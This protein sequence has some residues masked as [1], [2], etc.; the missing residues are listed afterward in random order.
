[1]NVVGIDELAPRRRS[2]RELLLVTV[3]APPEARARVVESVGMFEGRILGVGSTEVTVSLDG[4]PGKVDDFDDSSGSW[5]RRLAAHRPGGVAQLDEPNDSIQDNSVANVFYEKMLIVPHRRSRRRHHR[6]RLAGSRPRAEPEG[7]GIDVRIGVGGIGLK[8]KAEAAG[9]KVLSIATRWRSRRHHGPAPDT[10]QKAIYEA[11]I[12]ADLVDA[13]ALFFGHGF[14][15]RFGRMVPPPLWTSSWSPQ[16]PGH[17]VRRPMRRVGRALPRRVE[18]DASGHALGLGLAYADAIGG[19]RAGVIE[20]T[21]TEE[22]ETDLFG[23]QVVLCGGT[24]ALVQAGFET[25]I[26][27]GYQPEIAYF[28]CLHELKLIVDLMYEEG[29][30]GM[31]DPS[32]TPPVRGPTLGPRS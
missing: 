27:A 4:P 30:A 32:P 11:S 25:L 31:R 1:M 21:F 13:D 7:P 14:N 17:L 28:E 19:A 26:N 23:E 6:L 12:E 20:T 18:Q 16:G 2:T 15:I 10:E 5:D 29:I 8:A 9:L 24:T 3:S 22:T